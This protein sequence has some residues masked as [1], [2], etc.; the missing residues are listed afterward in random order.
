F[1]PFRKKMNIILKKILGNYYLYLRE[2]FFNFYVSYFNNKLIKDLSNNIYCKKANSNYKINLI[3]EFNSLEQFRI[4][5]LKK[6]E[7][8]KI[9]TFIKEI[10]DKK[11]KLYFGL[12]DKD[13]IIALQWVSIKGFKYVEWGYAVSKEYRKYEIADILRINW[14]KYFSKNK[15]SFFVRIM[16]NNK[17]LIPYFKK[18]GYSEYLFKDDVHYLNKK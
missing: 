16:H 5:E 18:R 17:I 12:F 1:I 9:H 15:I 11:K 14:E 3:E 10:F 8:S 4:K 7:H 2:Y 6:K 13:R